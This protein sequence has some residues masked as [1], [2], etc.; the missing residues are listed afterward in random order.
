MVYSATLFDPS[1][2]HL[3]GRAMTD[4]ATLIGTCNADTLHRVAWAFEW[5]LPPYRR[6]NLAKGVPIKSPG[7]KVLDSGGDTHPCT[8]DNT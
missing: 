7:S 6:F 4:S 5:V 3:N 2:V 1:N 8:L